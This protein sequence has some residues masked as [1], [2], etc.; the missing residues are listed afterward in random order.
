MKQIQR[1]AVIVIALAVALVGRTASAEPCP[2]TAG[3]CTV[4]LDNGTMGAKLD[5]VILGDGFTAAE[6]TKFET[7]SAVLA[8][9]LLAQDP[10]E[11]YKPMF[12]VYGLFTPSAQSG[13]DD[14]SSNHFV[15]TA[16]DASYD[17]NDIYYL[18]A[19]NDTKVFMEV[20]ARFPEA[21]LIVVVVNATAYGG[22]GGAVAVVSLD[23]NS[24]EIARH[25]VGHTV[26][27]LA[28]EYDTPYP[29]QPL[30][31]SEPNVAAIHHL[32]NLK[33]TPWVTPG[34][35]IPTPESA[36][37]GPLTPVGAYEG[38]RYQAE[39]MF[40]PAPTCIMKELEKPFCPVCTE[41]MIL[42][43][44]SLSS[45]IESPT[46][47]GAPTVAPENVGTTFSA[48]LPALPNLEVSWTLD[49]V[50][51]GVSAPT[52]VMNPATDGV[53]A[54][55]HDLVLRVAAPTPLVKTDPGN[56]LVETYAWTVFVTP[57]DCATQAGGTPCDDGD[58]CTTN[59]Q[60]SGG[61]CAGTPPMPCAA[62][63]MCQLA[64]TCD[65]KTGAC[66]YPPKPCAE[67]SGCYQPGVC[68]PAN[69]KCAFAKKADDAPCDDGDTCTTGDRCVD[70]KCTP[71]TTK[72]CPAGD[73]CEVASCNAFYGLCEI[74]PA[75]D[76]DACDDGNL[77][78]LVDTCDASACV[79]ESVVTC[80]APDECHDDGACD[81]GT[82]MC[83]VVT[84]ADGEA[85]TEGTCVAGVCTPVTKPPP[86]PPEEDGCGCR[87]APSPEP[88]GALVGVAVAAAAALRRRRRPAA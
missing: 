87:V 58:L 76:G 18:L 12:N 79:H 5:V 35:P 88:T 29:G 69:G 1:F 43:F 86:K 31:D 13:A 15:D 61:V 16:F 17:T 74:E 80:P 70:G 3:A 60:C 84:K 45:M 81:P 83:S 28:D 49:G 41:A 21:D 50:D 33:W 53:A 59:D 54:G 73:V 19:V 48:T 82:G 9:A 36:A 63:D 7:E 27:N 51:K 20:M 85:C 46:P 2:P 55:Y 71:T 57:I 6:Q 64:G 14:P 23:S 26:A 75:D 47:A 62:G 77:C 11:A 67:P 30:G 38:A 25:E 42:S 8:D 32:T 40:R 56:L 10:Y 52:F 78:T 68:N 72:T 39:N 34:T 65:F 37:T 44:A 22:A 24:V 66:V 4:L